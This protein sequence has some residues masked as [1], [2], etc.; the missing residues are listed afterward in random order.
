MKNNI[1]EN[2]DVQKANTSVEIYRR[3]NRSSRL[4]FALGLHVHNLS[5]SDSMLTLCIGDI[6]SYLHDDIA[7][8]LRETKKGGAYD[9][10]LES[11]K[12]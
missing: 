5:M 1:A 6:L 7:F 3:L 12:H 2:E 8:V 4:S 10:F 9:D 11:S